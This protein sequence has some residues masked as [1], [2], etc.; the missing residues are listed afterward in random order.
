MKIGIVGMGIVGSANAAGF[1][2]LGHSVKSHDIKFDTTI[3]NVLD[4]EIIFLCVPTPTDESNKCNTSIVEE[5][6]FELNKKEN[7]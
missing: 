4:T 2:L 3:D 1:T 5:V 6:I 7:R